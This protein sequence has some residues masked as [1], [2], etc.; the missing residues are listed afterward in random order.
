MAERIRARDLLNR[1][2]PLSPISDRVLITLLIFTAPVLA[3]TLIIQFSMGISFISDF[4][5]T[6]MVTT[7]N[8]THFPA[9]PPWIMLFTSKWVHYLFV[10]LATLVALVWSPIM[11][12]IIREGTKFL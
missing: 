5:Y 1:K 8:R 7:T 4:F 2:H 6:A 10:L 12:Q 3:A 9:S 11:G